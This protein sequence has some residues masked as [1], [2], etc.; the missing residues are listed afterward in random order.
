MNRKQLLCVLIGACF[1]GTALSVHGADDTTPQAK[2]LLEKK[3]AADVAKAKLSASVPFVYYTVPAMSNNRRNLYSYPEDGMLGGTLSFIQAQGEFESGSFVIYPY[4]DAK[5][6]TLKVSDLKGKNGVIPAANI[7]VRI[8]KIWV[9][10][11]LSWYS[12]FSDA[13][14]RTL[15]PELLLKDE[16]LVKVDREKMHNLL[17]VGNEGE[18]AWISMPEAMNVEVNVMR[19]DVKD[20]PTL[21]PFTLTKGEMRQIWIT[22]EAPKN[23]SGVYNG[24]IEISVDGKKAANVP[25]S[26]RVLPFELPRPMAYYDITKPFFA[27]SYNDLSLRGYLQAADGDMK[28]AETRLFNN[29]VSLRKHN[30]LYPMITTYR[31]G[32]DKNVYKRQ[33]ELYR[34]AGLGTD[35]LLDA[36]CGIPDYGYLS[37]PDRKKPLAEQKIP[38]GWEQTSTDLKPLLVEVFGQLPDCYGFGW[39]EP[40]MGT[41]K[42]Q[43]VAWK[44]LHDN[45]FKVYSTAHDN[46]LTHA[47]YN[48]DFVTYGGHTS[49]EDARPWHEMGAKITVYANPHTGLENPDFVRREHGLVL[50]KDDQDGTNNYMVSG[51]GWND[52]V[53]ESYNFRGFNWIY[54]ATDGPIETIQFEGFR[55]ALDDVRYATYLKQLATEAM[56]SSSTDAVYAG[57]LAM[58]WLARLDTKTSDLN[59]VRLEMINRIMD[60][61]KILAENK[62]K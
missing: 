10:T 61:R 30:L 3:V 23:A 43:R 33:L 47:G 31:L 50:Y 54:P 20:A 9:Q 26:V 53:G 55:E 35:I 40:G 11:G 13:G 19:E 57:K 62:K 29:Y 16:N 42:N 14:G 37:N 49:A 15:C 38:A 44:Y 4:A 18:H 45:G 8:V 1:A 27:G 5:S 28:K 39:D 41:L 25:V 32:H 2:Q 59:T 46:H 51:S 58:L 6:V 34:D 22:V 48:E 17:R 36:I 21:Q 52:F 24:D 7:D 60:L 56:A 12:Y